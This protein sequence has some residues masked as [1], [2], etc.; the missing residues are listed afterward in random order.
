[1]GDVQQAEL[2]V[3]WQVTGQAWTRQHNVAGPVRQPEWSG[4]LPCPYLSSSP[5]GSSM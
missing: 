3:V 4:S 5:R 2:E 1:M